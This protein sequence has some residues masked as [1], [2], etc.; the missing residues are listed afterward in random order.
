MEIGG[1]RCYNVERVC[2]QKKMG[3][4]P[5][6]TVVRLGSFP[7]TDWKASYKGPPL[8]PTPASGSG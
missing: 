1:G 8:F 2:P 4:M 7:E 3:A 5:E 6:D